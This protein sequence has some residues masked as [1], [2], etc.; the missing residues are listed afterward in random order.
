MTVAIT[1]QGHNFLWPAGVKEHIPSQPTDPPYLKRTWEAGWV[2][3]YEHLILHDIWVVGNLMM[4]AL[5]SQW[6][7]YGGYKITLITFRINNTSQAIQAF[8]WINVIYLSY[9]VNIY[10]HCEITNS[11]YQIC[12]IWRE[13]LS[14]SSSSNMYTEYELCNICFLILDKYYSLQQKDISNETLCSPH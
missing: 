4:K 10:L 3:S 5:Y 11:S 6:L 13:I 14:I 7:K 8:L 9:S 2:R 1:R 12:F